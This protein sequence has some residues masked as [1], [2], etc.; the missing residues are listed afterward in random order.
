MTHLSLMQESRPFKICED[1]HRLVL[2]FR[3]VCGQIRK[4]FKN[5]RAGSSPA[6]KE[7]RVL[8]VCQFYIYDLLEVFNWIGT[9]KT[10]PIDKEGGSASNGRL[11]V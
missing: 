8:V 2:S 9:A 3:R 4:D 10:M 5:K 7:P 11:S 1:W 6:Q